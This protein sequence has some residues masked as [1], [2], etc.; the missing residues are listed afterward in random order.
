MYSGCIAGKHIHVPDS[1]GALAAAVQIFH[2][3]FAGAMCIERELLKDVL[4]SA[5]A[6]TQI[7]DL[8]GS[9]LTV[10]CLTSF[11]SFFAGLRGF[12]AGSAIAP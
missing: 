7:V 11:R 10:I 8:L 2:Y 12:V 6:G 5:G 1:S 3:G 9:K 4:G